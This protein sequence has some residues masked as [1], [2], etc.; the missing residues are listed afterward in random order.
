M[1]KETRKVL[2]KCANCVIIKP[3]RLERCDMGKVGII[4]EFDKL[5]RLVIPKDL[6][7]RYAMDNKVEIV[8]T[9]QGILL[10]SPEYKLVKREEGD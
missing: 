7:E 10:K 9:E 5:G 4:K 3:E 8:A 1:N 6:R 2:T